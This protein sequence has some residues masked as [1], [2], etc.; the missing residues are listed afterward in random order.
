M[1]YYKVKVEKNS[2]Y[3]IKESELEIILSDLR[4]MAEDEKMTILVANMTDEEY[5]KL[6][7]FES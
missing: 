7:E 3:V 5:E 1:R 4:E 2:P 6:P